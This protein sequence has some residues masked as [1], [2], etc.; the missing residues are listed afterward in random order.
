MKLV[1]Q[2][3][4]YNGDFRQS[5]STYVKDTQRDV[6]YPKVLET[7]TGQGPATDGDGA[8][9]CF[10]LRVKASEFRV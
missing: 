5:G 3:K 10:G 1:T 9:S 2:K 8:A 7:A 4:N 6:L